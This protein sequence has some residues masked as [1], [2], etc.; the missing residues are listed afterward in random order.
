MGLRPFIVFSAGIDLRRQNLT[1][2]DVRF[3]RLRSV[4]ALKGLK[5]LNAPAQHWG[6]SGRTLLWCVCAKRAKTQSEESISF[7]RPTQP[8]SI[9]KPPMGGNVFYRVV[10]FR[11]KVWGAKIGK[12]AICHSESLFCV[13]SYL[14][15]GRQGRRKS[16]S[17]LT[18]SATRLILVLQVHRHVLWFKKHP[19]G[20]VAFHCPIRY[21]KCRNLADFREKTTHRIEKTCDLEKPSLA[22]GKMVCSSFCF[23]SLC[24]FGAS[25]YEPLCFLS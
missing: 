17:R 5:W 1:S 2:T 24:R 6:K 23:I 4:F 22:V 20:T 7:I 10:H 21:R 3:W 18:L 19:L 14:H 15:R 9:C 12:N 13:W 25:L 16:W 8:L 11:L